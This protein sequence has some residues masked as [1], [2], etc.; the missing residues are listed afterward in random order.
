MPTMKAALYQGNRKLKVTTIPRP[1]PGPGEALVRVRS[2]GVCGSDLL[3]W[4]DK[5]E[6]ETLPAGHEVAG[7][8]V[9]VGKGVSKS[10]VGDH[11]AIDI[12]GM[13]LRC[14]TC[15]YCRIGQTIH[16]TNKKE[17]TGGGYAQYIMRNAEG[18]FAIP[19]RVSWE[20]SALVEP[21][22]VSV[23]GVRRGRMRPGETVLVL[24]AG[25]IGQTCVAAARAMGAGKVIITARHPH[26]AKM[27]KRLGAD[28]VLPDHGKE[29]EEGIKDATGGR[30]ADVTLES[31]GGR[32]DTTIQQALQ[33][34]R[35]QGR[36][37]ILGGF[38][39]PISI[40]WIKPLLNEH[41]IVFSSC[42]GVLEGRDDY[43]VAIDL[44]ADKRVNIKPMVT[45]KFPLEDVQK[46]LDTA[47]DKTVG[48]IKVQ[49]HQT[50]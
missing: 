2:E 17:G 9:E 19:K 33:F 29:L 44:I 27:A 23:H 38:W 1:E 20:E 37:V 4:W 21:L 26:Q 11:V 39:V 14:G 8:I 42:Y 48:S 43:E 15:W 50:V 28:V 40:D 22:A 18:C 35:K 24:G 7:E 36:I 31:V 46:A 13:G 41:S 3:I 34:T 25:N 6:K 16:C 12:L 47:Y 32:T 10:R 45:H 30:G 49:I 5:K